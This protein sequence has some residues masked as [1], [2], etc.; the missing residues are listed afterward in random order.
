MSKISK[1]GKDISTF[2]TKDRN[3]TCGRKG[4]YGFKR[5]KVTVISPKNYGM[6]LQKTKCR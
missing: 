6:F 3:K 5:E 1:S 4:Y 2:Y